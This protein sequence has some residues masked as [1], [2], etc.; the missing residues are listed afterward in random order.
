MITKD[1]EQRDREAQWCVHCET[2]KAGVRAWGLC[3]VCYLDPNIRGLYA[4]LE[5]RKRDW[6]NGSGQPSR[7]RCK[8]TSAMP[9]TI[10]KVKVL[11]Q[12]AR[13]NQELWHPDDAT[14]MDEIPGQTLEGLL[15][16]VAE[17]E[18]VI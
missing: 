6:S 4:D 12:R 13:D 2:G 5:R 11:M 17:L 7:K 8:P 16:V 18:G 1:Q 14:G 3:Q 10:A 9:G 15:G